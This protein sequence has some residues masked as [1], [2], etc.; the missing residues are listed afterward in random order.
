MDD[1]ERVARASVEA[2][3]AALEAGEDEDMQDR[4]ACEAAEAEAERQ[5]MAAQ[6]KPWK[7]VTS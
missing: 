1:E 2:A 3:E 4:L 7:W 6:G 5:F